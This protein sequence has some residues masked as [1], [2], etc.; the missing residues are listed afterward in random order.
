CDVAF[1]ALVIFTALQ[2]QGVHFPTLWGSGG[3]YADG[4]PL[5]HANHSDGDDG[6]MIFIHFLL[7][8]SLWHSNGIFGV[9]PLLFAELY[10]IFVFNNGYMIPCAYC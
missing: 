6:L 10:I 9:R 2:N 1:S 4:C 5:S 3:D 7:S 8:Y